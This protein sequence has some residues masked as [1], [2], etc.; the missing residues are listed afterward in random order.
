MRDAKYKNM[1]AMNPGA[2]GI[3]GFHKMKTVLRFSI[4]NGK[5]EN[6]EAIELGKRGE[7]K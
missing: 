1:L 4:H 5:M 6:L 3:H 7:I 2:A